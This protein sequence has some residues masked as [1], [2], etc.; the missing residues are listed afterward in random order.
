MTDLPRTGYA[1]RKRIRRILIGAILLLGVA[2]AT[3]GL[4][5]LKPA[6]PTVDR[7][8]V[9]LGEVEAGP[10]SIEVRGPGTLVPEEIRW[11]AAP[12][13]GRV[14]RIKVLPGTTVAADSVLMTLDN[15]ELQQET[16]S[17]ELQ[18]RQATAELED[19]K[20]ELE[21]ARLTQEAQT[22]AVSA[23]YQQYRL[24]ADLNRKLAQEGLISD[25]TLKLAEVTTEELSKRHAIEQKRLEIAGASATA[26]IAAKEAQISQLRG[27]LDLKRHQ[28]GLLQVRAGIAGVLQ[29]TP[30]EVGRQVQPGEILGKVAVPGKLKAELR[31]PETQAKDVQIGLGASIDI[32][33]GVIPGKVIRIDPAAEAGT[34]K[35]D[36]A[37]AGELPPGARP[38]LNVDGTI[39]ID[40]LD[41]V[42]KM[43]RPAFGQPDST[44]TLFKLVGDGEEAVR[45][46]VRLGR[47][48]VTTIQVLEG[49]RP[50]DQVI[51]SDVSAWDDTDRIRLK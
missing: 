25:L 48:S 11:I 50:G 18:L 33:S 8:S 10:M 23:D 43:G 13:S 42:V 19:L 36:V 51:L 26:R 46:Q 38:D 44:V 24:Q 40:H 22:A 15:P 29:Q 49:L 17:A 5:R 45:V 4:S 3:W 7:S 39:E 9:W 32:R 30:V 34:V 31:I 16:L 35:V 2:A 47:S 37:L 28:V 6:A 12:V 20:V 14:E 21:S 1:R 27:L 41:D